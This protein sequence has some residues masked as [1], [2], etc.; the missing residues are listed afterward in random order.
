ML[1]ALSPDPTDR[2]LEIGCGRGVAVAAI[3]ERLTTGTILAIDRSATAIAAARCRNAAAVRAS[4]A[5]FT[6]VALADLAV[7][8]ERFDKIFAVNVNLFWQGAADELVV[9][10]RLLA[11][12]G[13]LHLVFEPPTAAQVDR[14]VREAVATLEA[15]SFSRVT[16]RTQVGRGQRLIHVAAA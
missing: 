12:R 11:S 2:L 1:E 7:G 10:R 13:R 8:L 16:V 4:K 5:A 3:C 14:I 9:I 6:T 15:G